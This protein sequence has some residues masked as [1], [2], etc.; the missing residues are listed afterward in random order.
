MEVEPSFPPMNPPRPFTTRAELNSESSTNRNFR[1]R[2]PVR[3]G[4]LDRPEGVLG[5]PEDKNAPKS[6]PPK[7][8]HS[9]HSSTR[10]EQR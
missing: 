6:A 9:E 3:G 7:N 1:P 4:G 10:L 5:F 8:A 2:F